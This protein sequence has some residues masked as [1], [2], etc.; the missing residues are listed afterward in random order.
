MVHEGEKLSN[1]VDAPHAFVG[2]YVGGKSMPS[3]G[4]KLTEKTHGQLYHGPSTKN[5]VDMVTSGCPCRLIVNV[6]QRAA[7]V[8]QAIWVVTFLSVVILSV[9][10]GLYVG[11]VFAFFTVV[12]R[13]QM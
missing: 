5:R 7:F 10:Y 4:D 2:T 1:H 3:P 9:D 12:T 6:V 11:I 8:W 13:S